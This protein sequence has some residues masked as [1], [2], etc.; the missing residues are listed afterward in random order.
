MLVKKTT[1]ILPPFEMPLPP[2]SRPTTTKAF[3]DKFAIISK[4]NFEIFC[5]SMERVFRILSLNRGRREKKR[6]K[7]ERERKGRNQELKKR[8]SVFFFRW[9][10]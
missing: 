8:F 6:K 10:G 4:S 7:G 1:R 2:S 9:L 5:E 3:F